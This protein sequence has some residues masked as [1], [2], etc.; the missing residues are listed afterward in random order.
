MTLLVETDSARTPAPVAERLT[1]LPPPETTTIIY[2]FDNPLTRQREIALTDE[3]ILASYKARHEEAKITPCEIASVYQAVHIS[4][5]SGIVLKEAEIDKYVE[6]RLAPEN[7]KSDQ[8]TIA[9]ILALSKDPKDHRSEIF[10]RG[11]PHIF[12]PLR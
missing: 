9:Q 1:L 4:G 5:R 2:G 11:L 7:R 10:K 6:L 3:Q 12:F 8:E